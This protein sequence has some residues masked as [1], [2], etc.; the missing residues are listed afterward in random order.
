MAAQHALENRMRVGKNLPTK[1]APRSR[2][3]GFES[4]KRPLYSGPSLGTSQRK[5][6]PPPRELICEPVRVTRR[7]HRN[8]RQKIVICSLGLRFP[9][10]CIYVFQRKT[11]LG[12]ALTEQPTDLITG[13][14]LLD[15]SEIFLGQH[16]PDF[17]QALIRT[18]VDHVV[19][20]AVRCARIFQVSEPSTLA[21]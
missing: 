19:D 15:E 1:P 2:E 18:K 6:Q 3:A 20:E 9:L 4:T 10:P 11:M 14:P 13:H 5:N 12:R 8:T 21:T 7:L 16:L 17:T